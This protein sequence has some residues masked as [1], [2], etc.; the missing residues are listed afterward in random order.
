[1]NIIPYF[2]FNF[3]NKKKFLFLLNKIKNKINFIEIGIP[4]SLI[5][6]CFISKIKNKIDKIF[7]KE[8]KNILNNKNYKI[9]LVCSINF[10]LKN[11]NY[12][13]NIKVLIFDIPWNY[14]ICLNKYFYIKKIKIFIIPILNYRNSFYILKKFFNNKIYRNNI[15]YLKNYFGMPGKKN[16][17]FL[18]N[19]IYNIILLYKY[20]YFKIIL[21]FGISISFINKVKEIS[22]LVIGTNFIKQIYYVKN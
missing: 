12:F 17:F 13:K 14:L 2:I 9:I 10:F 5:D 4:D 22:N 21:G 15:I 3:P 18:K 16:L 7:I 11:I 20:G 19:R 1:M 8:I 6:G